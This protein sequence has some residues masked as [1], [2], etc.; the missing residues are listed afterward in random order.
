MSEQPL[1]SVVLPVFNGE[2]YLG[3]TLRSAL[4]QTWSNLELLVVDDGS[5]DDSA[6]VV[7]QA[8]EHDDRVRL[9]EHDGG[10]NRGVSRSRRLALDHSRGAF[11]AFLDADD[12]WQREKLET[13][14]AAMLSHTGAV[15][16][17]ADGKPGPLHL[18][19]EINFSRERKLYD[20]RQ[21][22][23][24]GQSNPICQSSVLC[25]AEPVKATVPGFDQLFQYEDWTWW[26]L[27]SPCGPFLFL[28]RALT[29]Y[30]V[31]DDA[32]TARLA[33]SGL[34]QTYSTIEHWL[35]VMAHSTDP[36]VRERA[37]G[38]LTVALG[39]AMAGYGAE[40]GM[41]ELDR[42]DLLARLGAQERELATLRRW[43]PRRLVGWWRRRQRVL[44]E[45]RG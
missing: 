28:P 36:V 16:V 29:T 20:P 15:I 5:T 17:N 19:A 18:E 11:V 21:A 43:L 9:L 30:R 13:Q 12:L 10:V 34:R 45:R 37:S 26:T 44:L 24:F 40:S 2:R 3:E 39:E 25:R 32:A 8:A 7:K 41:V 1:V 22:D 38:Q 42:A 4:S 6:A 35:A 33:G 31:H 23:W 14:V 27:L